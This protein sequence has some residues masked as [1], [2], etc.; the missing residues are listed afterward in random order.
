[1]DYRHEWKISL[2]PGDL[3]VLRQR[4]RAVMQPDAHAVDGHTASG[5]SILTRRRIGRCAKSW[6]A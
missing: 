1:M 3:F 2:D 4:L 5:A 6:T